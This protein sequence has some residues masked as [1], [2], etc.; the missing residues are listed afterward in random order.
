[1][2]Y[3]LLL[4]LVLN[5]GAL[6]IG[7][8]FTGSGVPSDWYQNLAKAPWTPPGWVFSFAWTLI[9]LCFSLYLSQLWPKLKAKKHF[10]ILFSLQWIL[11]VAWNPIFFYFHWVL[12]GLVV[13]T[14][15]TSLIAY[16]IL[17]YRPY[18]KNGI[19]LLLPYLVWLV[20]ASSLNAY[21]LFNN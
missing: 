5:F 15:L 8:Y 1:M 11:N 7:G 16:F 19:L 21:V 4:F 2:L 18:W 17:Y 3:R 14:S 9:M 13:I 12:A 10:L 6:A 20:I